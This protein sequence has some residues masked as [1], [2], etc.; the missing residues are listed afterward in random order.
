MNSHLLGIKSKIEHGSIE[1]DVVRCDPKETPNLANE[2]EA[3]V[4]LS[5]RNFHAGVSCCSNTASLVRLI[6]LVAKMAWPRVHRQCL[7]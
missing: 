4:E 2:F 5:Y 1:A 6:S 3:D 7:G